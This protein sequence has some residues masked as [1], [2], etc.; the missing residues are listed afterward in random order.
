MNTTPILTYFLTNWTDQQ[1][2][3]R[4]DKIQN[5]RSHVTIAAL[6]IVER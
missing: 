2:F 6:F 3:C 1:R 5:K 4:A